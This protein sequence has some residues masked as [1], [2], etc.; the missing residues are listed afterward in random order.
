MSKKLDPEIAVKALVDL[1]RATGNREIQIAPHLQEHIAMIASL[2]EAKGKI[3][4]DGE[5][6]M[7]SL[8][9]D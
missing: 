7:L 2:P 6:R 4:F 1:L 3:S 9:D 5:N 8:V